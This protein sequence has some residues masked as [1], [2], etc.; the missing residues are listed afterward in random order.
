MLDAHLKSNVQVVSGAVGP[1]YWLE[2]S[3]NGV[4][5]SA[6]VDTGSQST[7]VSRNFLHK[8][9]RHLHDERKS[10]PKL[11]SP[12]TKLRGKGGYIIDVVAQVNLTFSLEGKSIVTPVFVQPDSEQECM[13]GSNVIG[14]IGIT[15]KCA[16]SET[17]SVSMGNNSQAC[18][19]NLIQAT[20][21]SGMNDCYARAQIDAKSCRGQDLLFEPAHNELEPPG[22][23]ATE[24][25]ISVN[26]EGVAIVPVQNF[27]GVCVHLDSGTRLGTVRKC[28]LLDVEVN[29][30]GVIK[31]DEVACAHVKAFSDES[32][33]HNKLLEEL[34]LARCKLKPHEL[35]QLRQCYLSTRMCLH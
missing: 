6:M 1:S 15:V 35:A 12:S 24:S 10:V 19:V 14:A 18:H 13:L 2:L 11:E 20:S 8:V 4:V 21:V 3:V 32:R 17:V 22:I 30:S 9:C 23:S 33:R 29:P 25:L 26:S 7:I 16:N 34:N 27:Q 28:D 5:V 31:C